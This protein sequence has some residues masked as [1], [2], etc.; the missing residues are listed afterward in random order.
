[1]LRAQLQTQPLILPQQLP[2]PPLITSN[3]LHFLTPYLQKYFLSLLLLNLQ[4][5]NTLPLSLPQLLHEVLIL[6]MQ[7]SI[8]CP[9]QINSILFQYQNILRN[10]LHHFLP[11][12]PYRFTHR[13]VL[14]WSSYALKLVY[15]CLDVGRPVYFW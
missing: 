8:F 3:Q 14:V 13:L 2:D 11:I 12:I 9:K 6:L 4:F 1:M 15:Y 7:V 5:L 10:I